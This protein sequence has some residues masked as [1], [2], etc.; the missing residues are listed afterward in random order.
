MELAAEPLRA[1]VWELKWDPVWSLNLLIF[2][3]MAA[4]GAKKRGSKNGPQKKSMKNRLE[5]ENGPAA[6]PTPGGT[7]AT[8]KDIGRGKPLPM[9]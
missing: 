4:K 7:E 8:G 5:V 1:P 3:Q 2:V 9:E 6:D